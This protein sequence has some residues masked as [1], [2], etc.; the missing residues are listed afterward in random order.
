M[1]LILIINFY[2]CFSLNILFYRT[3]RYFFV[4]KIEFGKYLYFSSYSN[5]YSFLLGIICGYVYMRY[6]RKNPEN[7]L[8][9]GKILKVTPNIGWPMIMVIIYLG[10]TI[11]LCDKTSL[12]LSMYG[13]LQRHVALTL[14]AIIVLLR[15]MCLSGGKFFLEI[16]LKFLYNLHNTY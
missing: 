5:L 3:F 10:A 16:N 13:L 14:V 8:K 11:M 1:L 12:W 7:K 15:G 9:L 6:L 4:Q 2:Y